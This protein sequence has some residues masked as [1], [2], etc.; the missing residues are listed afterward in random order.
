MNHPLP[1]RTIDGG[2]AGD[3]GLPVGAI[4]DADGAAVCD[5]GNHGEDSDTACEG[6]APDHDDGIL[7]ASAPEMEQALRKVTADY[8]G[9]VRSDRELSSGEIA[10]GMP[11]SITEARA[12][13]AR[14]DAARAEALRL[15]EEAAKAAEHNRLRHEEL[16]AQRLREDE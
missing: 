10:G 13:L 15:A 1:W 2:E 16:T 8:E 12:L 14:F 4:V 9:I 3:W 6:S 11:P 5:F 7:L